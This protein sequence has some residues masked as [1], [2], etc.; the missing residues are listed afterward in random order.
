MLKML[1]DNYILNLMSYEYINYNDNGYDN[2]YDNLINEIKK[3]DKNYHIIKRKFTE[4]KVKLPIKFY[5]SNEHG[6]FI[7]NAITGERYNGLYV[8]SKEEDNFFKVRFCNGDTEKGVTLFY[9]DPEEYENHQGF[10]VSE[11][12]KKKWQ[13]KK[14]KIKK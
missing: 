4:F 9:E 7:R 8:G 11:L 14:L 6:G 3:Y 12:N 1:K 2:G 5:S 10:F 13:E